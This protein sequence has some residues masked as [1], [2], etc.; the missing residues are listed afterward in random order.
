[1]AAYFCQ[2]FSLKCFVNAA[3]SVF[4]TGIDLMLLLFAPGAV[5]GN[6]T[7]LD[8]HLLSINARMQPTGMLS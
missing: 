4:F 6:I 3:V 7:G 1:M 2:F 5:F 8:S